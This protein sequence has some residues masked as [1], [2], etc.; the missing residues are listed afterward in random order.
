MFDERIETPSDIIQA[1]KIVIRPGM[2]PCR[3]VLRQLQTDPYSKYVVHTQL[4]EQSTD[5][6]EGHSIALKHVGFD[7]G[8]YCQ[9]LAEAEKRFGERASRL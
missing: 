1:S 9:E 8:D 5:I 2:R 7:N 4:L 3:V 6:R